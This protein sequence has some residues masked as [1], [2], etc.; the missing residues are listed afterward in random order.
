MLYAS[1]YVVTETVALLLNRL[2]TNVVRRFM[3][4]NLPA[5]EVV[6][7]DQPMHKAALTAM[8][9]TP[10][11]RGPSLTDCANMEVMRHLKCDTIFAYDRRFEGRGFNVIG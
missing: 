10:G 3:D 7:I 11:R 9:A 4:D 8:L 1:S 6:W 5:V 2:G